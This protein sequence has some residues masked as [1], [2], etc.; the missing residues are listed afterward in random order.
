MSWLARLFG[1]RKSRAEDADGGEVG[2]APVRRIPRGVDPLSL[3]PVAA[4]S[5]IRSAWLPETDEGDIG[6]GS[7]FGGRPFLP[8]GVD[9]PICPRCTRPMPLLAQLAL[10][11]LPPGGPQRGAG[12]LQAFYCPTRDERGFTSCNTELQGWAAFSACHVVRL[13]AA[14]SPGAPSDAGEPY[15]AL[16]VT[17][18]RQVNDWPGWEEQRALGIG[19][20][21]DLANAISDAGYPRTGE[22]LGGWPAWV[23]SL[24]YPD[25]PRCG[26]RMD[27]L[28]QIDSEQLLPI[29]FGDVG[30]GH[31]TQCP[32]HPDV[33]TFAWACS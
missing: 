26:A 18:W 5:H 24:E 12:L 28:L 20:E 3:L 25:C 32:D 7:G 21:E 8:D 33:L 23:Q 19:I 9:H 22:K 4:R 11:D 16:H 14:D 29:M 10:A 13:V 15:P 30:T 1:G 6:R 27:V 31:V 2:L 17:G